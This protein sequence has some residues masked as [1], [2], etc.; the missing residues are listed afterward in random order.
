MEDAE[1]GGGAVR[2]A[3]IANNTRNLA[4]SSHFFFSCIRVVVPHGSTAE[5]RSPAGSQQTR[6]E[7]AAVLR[8]PA[9][10]AR[11]ARL[12]LGLVVADD[13]E[14]AVGRPRRRRRRSLRHPSQRPRRDAARA[15]DR[16][17][18]AA[19]DAGSER[20][21]ELVPEIRHDRERRPRDRAPIRADRGE[22]AEYQIFGVEFN[23]A[24][25]DRLADFAR[26]EGD[27]MTDFAE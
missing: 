9:R 8:G 7:H 23:A 24:A 25:S 12:R 21:D 18:N 17:Q 13:L 10:H 4:A 15:E 2:H 1:H 14:R 20:D 6:R 26:E 27:P 3:H 11:H 22:R 19:H 16:R 5:L